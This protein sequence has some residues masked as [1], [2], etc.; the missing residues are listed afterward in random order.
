M[1][2][3][4]ERMRGIGKELIVLL[5]VGFEVEMPLQDEHLMFERVIGY[6]APPRMDFNIPKDPP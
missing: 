1:Q 2:Q 4:S 6:H 3:R 5:W